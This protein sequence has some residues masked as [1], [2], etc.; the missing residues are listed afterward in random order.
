MGLPGKEIVK[1]VG[2]WVGVWR[3]KEGA[4]L[5]CAVLGSAARTSLLIWRQFP[6][7]RSLAREGITGYFGPA[8]N[9]ETLFTLCCT[10]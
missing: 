2:R 5:C 6:E 4:V 3:K 8:N 9:K 7:S 10:L 1:T